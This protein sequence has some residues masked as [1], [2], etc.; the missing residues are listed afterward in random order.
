MPCLIVLIA[1]AM[2]RLAIVLLYLFTTFFNRAYDSILFVLLG[3]LFLPFT[4]IAYAWAIN[5]HHTVDGLYLVVV[6]VAVLADLGFLGSGEAVRRR[7]G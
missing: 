3:F 4:T 7:Q 5:V 6:V 2:P 1:L